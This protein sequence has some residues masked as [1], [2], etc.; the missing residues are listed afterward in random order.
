MPAQPQTGATAEMLARDSTHTG[1]SSEATTKSLPTSSSALPPHTKPLKSPTKM[2]SLSDIA[3]R[4]KIDKERDSDK[5]NGGNTATNA[6]GRPRL[7]LTGRLNSVTPTAIMTGETEAGADKSQGSWGLPASDPSQLPRSGTSSPTKRSAA[8]KGLP[9]LEEIQERMAKK[10][11]ASAAS[12]SSC[13][14]SPSPSMASATTPSEATTGK[15]VEKAATS[16]QPSVNPEAALAKEKEEEER[17]RSLAEKE[18]EKKPDDSAFK[19]IPEGRVADPSYSRFSTSPEKSSRI[20]PPN[21]HNVFGASRGLGSSTSSSSLHPDRSARGMSYP[22]PRSYQSPGSPVKS[23]SDVH[24]LQHRWTLY[25]DSKTFNPSSAVSTPASTPQLDPSTMASS[26]PPSSPMG[27][28]A[29]SSTT[30]SYEAALKNLGAHKTVE[31]FFSTY[32]TLKRPSKLERNSNYHLFKDGIKPMWE[33]PSNANGGKWTLTFKNQ[34][35]ALLDR[36]WMWLVLALIGE[37]LDEDDEVTGAVCSTRPRGDR[38]ALWMRSKNEVDKVNKMGRKLV[39]LLDVEKEPGISLEFSYNTG[40]PLEKPTRFISLH[41]PQI[42]AFTI[43]GGHGQ[44]GVGGA[45]RM[46]LGPRS[47]SLRQGA[48]IGGVGAPGPQS[49]FGAPFQRRNSEQ[50]PGAPPGGP[51]LN[52]A[53]GNFGGMGTSSP[54]MGGGGLSR[55]GSRNVH[56]GT[57]GNNGSPSMGPL[58]TSLGI[59]PSGFGGGPNPGTG[60]SH[61]PSTG[62]IFG[63]TMKNPSPK[64]GTVPLDSSP[65]NGGG[66]GL[67][68]GALGR[69]GSSGAGAEAK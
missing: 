65:S 46:G 48:S 37:E 36:S 22:A 20:S 57:S 38:I 60:A 68:T 23:K 43:A 19:P 53:G 40:Q 1:S 47:T 9:T 11:L 6:E 4:M 12:S 39:Q 42:N 18:W 2:P 29:S 10:G 55:T 58:G 66:Q 33:D 34:N 50:G 24:P 54:A 59:G 13:E 3:A 28:P 21:Q 17:K 5:E 14:K 45:D 27:L 44:A 26:N 25:F 63:R 15:P 67:G 30:E 35:P 61:A 31:S 49:A 69:R 16:V 51:G 32:A 7:G 52:M 56:L 8:A 41:N 62:G 64:L